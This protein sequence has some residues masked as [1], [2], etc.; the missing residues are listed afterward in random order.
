MYLNE[1]GSRRRTE[2]SHAGSCK[3]TNIDLLAFFQIQYVNRQNYPASVTQ[4][5]NINDNPFILRLQNQNSR[6][7]ALLIRKL[8]MCSCMRIG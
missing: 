7:V 6:S 2:P 5:N 8:R 3:R 4:N 1:T